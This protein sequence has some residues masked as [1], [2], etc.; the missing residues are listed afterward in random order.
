MHHF[1]EILEQGQNTQLA[2]QKW[3]FQQKVSDSECV[4]TQ[5]D[6][7]MAQKIFLRQKLEE[8]LEGEPTN[9]HH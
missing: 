9:M 8:D 6:P 3:I 4:G 1:R 7:K 5:I 2:I